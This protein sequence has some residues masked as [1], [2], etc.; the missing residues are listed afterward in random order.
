M[1]RAAAPSGRNLLRARTLSDV[2]GGGPGG[3]PRIVVFDGATG[4][5]V[6]D[7]FA[8]DP[9]DRDDPQRPPQERVLHPVAQPRRQVVQPELFEEEPR[10]ND[11]INYVRSRVA[12]WRDRNYPDVSPVTR[13]LLNHWRDPRRERRLYFCQVEAVE[14]PIFLTEAAEQAGETVF[15]DKR[16]ALRTATIR[17]A[18]RFQGSDVVPAELFPDLD[19]AKVVI[20]IYHAV[21]LKVVI[22]AETL[23]KP[24]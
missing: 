17:P 10:E 12:L 8:F 3:P 21:Q 22:E 1:L 9:A 13:Q 4:A 20:W 24:H 5:R 7:Y 11:D 15:L 2:V 23:T 16:P 18:L 6:Q 14:T 19:A